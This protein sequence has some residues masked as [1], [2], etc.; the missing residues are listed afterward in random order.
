MA[1][2]GFVGCGSGNRLRPVV[3]RD[4]ERVPPFWDSRQGLF[5]Y[6]D[7]TRCLRRRRL[8]VPRRV[9]GQMLKLSR[10]TA[11]N[12]GSPR[13]ERAMLRSRQPARMAARHDPA[14]PGVVG[15][16]WPLW[17]RDPSNAAP[18]RSTNDT[19]NHH[20]RMRLP[21]QRPASFRLRGS[22]AHVAAN[23][24]SRA[25][26]C[27]GE[28]GPFSGIERTVILSYSDGSQ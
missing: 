6:L 22:V 23:Q 27:L 5:Q 3:A 19:V 12:H 7:A 8:V 2:A 17:S 14:V 9:A 24:A 15:K 13:L 4:V 1:G 11:L 25:N 26:S 18:I 10:A 21:R 20:S 16:P 28:E